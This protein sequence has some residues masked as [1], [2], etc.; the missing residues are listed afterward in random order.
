MGFLVKIILPYGKM[1]KLNVLRRQGVFLY[2][3]CLTNVHMH[4]I[5]VI[6][7]MHIIRL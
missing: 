7:H 3:D 2:M 1:I 5:L 6:E 4:T